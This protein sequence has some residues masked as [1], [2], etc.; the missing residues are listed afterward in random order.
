MGSQSKDSKGYE[1]Q[2]MWDTQRVW[3]LPPLE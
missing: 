2:S 3:K 1:L